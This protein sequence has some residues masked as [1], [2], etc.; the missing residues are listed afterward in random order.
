MSLSVP[1]A[2]ILGARHQGLGAWP[3]GFCLWILAGGGPWIGWMPCWPQPDGS[4]S[5]RRQQGTVSG[6]MA[7]PLAGLT[8]FSRVA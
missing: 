6:V 5:N 3:S 4:A 8:A 2:P 7:W 1:W